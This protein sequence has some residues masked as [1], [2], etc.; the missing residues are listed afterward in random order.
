MVVDVAVVVG[1][2]VVVAVVVVVVVVVTRQCLD[3][4]V[5]STYPKLLIDGFRA[6]DE[7]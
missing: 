5:S 7:S 6:K 3:Y 4:R 2:V 1:L